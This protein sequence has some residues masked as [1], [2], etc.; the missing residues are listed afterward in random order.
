MNHL[1]FVWV[2]MN[3]VFSI[4]KSQEQREQTKP[5]T[6]PIQRSSSA[7]SGA[8]LQILYS[9]TNQ[10][11]DDDGGVCPEGA[12]RLDKWGVEDPHGLPA[13]GGGT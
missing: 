11:L 9:K 4:K 13:A 3:V 8:F 7:L 1:A 2:L 10:F 12:A 5:P 6:V